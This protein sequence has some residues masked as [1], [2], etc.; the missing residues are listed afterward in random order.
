MAL[1]LMISWLCKLLEI[2]K[3]RVPVVKGPH[4]WGNKWKFKEGIITLEQTIPD[5]VRIKACKPRA[6]EC[7][8]GRDEGPIK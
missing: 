1:L 7:G 2:S 8:R 5:E 4:G 3:E 6:G